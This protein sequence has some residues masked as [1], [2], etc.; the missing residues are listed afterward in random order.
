M[1]K[2]KILM[3]DDEQDYTTIT[4]VYLEEAWECE[5]HPVNFSTQ[6]LASAKAL[7]PDIILL[8]ISMPDLSG[9]EL[10]SQLKK[11]PDFKNTPIVFFTGVAD[12]I[13]DIDAGK[14]KID[15]YPYLTK[16]VSGEV[17]LAF[18]KKQLVR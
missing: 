2:P 14:R 7:R 12:D 3:V 11:D 18:I 17:L 13:D 5:V 16:P 15:G 8:D 1:T 4:K 10:A 6:G 9:R